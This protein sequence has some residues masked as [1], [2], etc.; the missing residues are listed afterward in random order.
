MVRNDQDTFEI[1][2]KVLL[3]VAD[4]AWQGKLE[5]EKDSLP[6]KM[7]PGPKPQFRCCV[8]REREIIRERIRLAQGICP[9]GHDTKNIVQVITAAC[10]D[11]PIQR[12]TVTSNCQNCLGKACMNSCHFGAISKGKDRV[13]IDHD[14]CRECGMCAKACPYNAITES[15]RPCI[16]TCPVDAITMDEYGLCTIDEKKCIQ[17]GMCTHGCPFDAIGVKSFMVDVINMIKN[18]RKV[19]A[20]TAPATEGQF[21][22]EITMDSWRT[23]LKKIGF[24][25][26]KEL[27][28]GGDMTAG[29]EAKEWA[30]AYD[31]GEK[32]TTSCC[33]AFVN[34]IR[35]HYPE[36]ADRIS[37]TVS[38]MCAVSRLLK[39]KDPYCVTVFIGPCQAKKSEALDI[40]NKGNADYVLTYDEILAMLEAKGVRLEAEPFREKQATKFGKRF[41]DSGGVSSEV[42]QCMKEEG[43]DPS[44]IKV[45]VC[46][47]AAECRKA[48]LL[49]RAGKLQDDFIEGMVCTDGCVGGPAR[50]KSPAE[51]RR[52]RDA[53]IAKAGLD[54]VHEN[55]KAQEADQIE[56]HT[57]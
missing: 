37:T 11:C 20:M 53:M 51:F 35:L 56:M 21:G 12:F 49:L 13:H 40:S 19:I 31:R 34:M 48:L 24:A 33:P 27:G 9:S 30:E 38:P 14:K 6:Y 3:E 52:D 15:V 42:L 7:I 41:G 8:Y 22:P 1:T 46:S 2:K 45:S 23:A 16:R 26:M 47:G 55:L 39:E 29:A 18:G 36:L 25:D 10:E 5:E 28:L 57:G 50:Q 32:K 43:R 4:L 54:N 17:C 44:G